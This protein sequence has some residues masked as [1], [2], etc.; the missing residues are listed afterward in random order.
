MSDPLLTGAAGRGDK[1]EGGEVSHLYTNK[2][3]HLPLLKN[4]W[5]FAALRARALR[6]PVFLGSSKRKTGHWPPPPLPPF[7][8]SLLVPARL[9]LCSEMRENVT[10]SLIVQYQL[11]NATACG[12]VNLNGS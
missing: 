4:L 2:F 5:V 8:A 7:A 11:N 3:A 1:E 12:T 9:M 10:A 6:V